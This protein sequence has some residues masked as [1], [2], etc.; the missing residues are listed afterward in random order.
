MRFLATG[1]SNAEFADRLRPSPS[2]PTCR[3]QVSACSMH[4][5]HTEGHR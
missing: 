1:L 4:H 2:A 3:L 5:L